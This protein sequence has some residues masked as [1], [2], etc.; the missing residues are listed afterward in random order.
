M[1]EGMISFGT[2]RW[3][4]RAAAGAACLLAA[5]CA[6]TAHSP[7]SAAPAGTPAPG[8]EE[9]TALKQTGTLL[10][11][12]EQVGWRQVQELLPLLDTQPGANFPGVTALAGDLRALASAAP[13]N[14]GVPPIEIGSVVDHNAHFWS[15]YYEI[16]PGDPLM[17]MLHVGLLLAAGEVVRADRVATL[18]INFGRMELE[19]RKELVGLDAHAQIVI[20]VSRGGAEELERLH[21]AKE[22]AKLADQARAELAVWP[23][24][25]VA[26]AQLAAAQQALGRQAAGGGDA[27]ADQSLAELHR[28]DPLFASDGP[29]AGAEPALKET[30]RCWALI[31]DDKATGDDEVLEQFARGAQAAGLDELALVAHSLVA[32][33]HEGSTPLEENF[34]Q[35]SLQR[36]VAPEVAA[37]ICRQ[38][39][40]PDHEWLGLSRDG[41]LPPSNLEGVSVHPQLEQ[42]L[43]VQIAATS[44]WIE[45]GLAQ[46]ADLA[47]DYSER[48]E[49]WAQLLQTDDA[50][51]D[52]RRSLQLKPANEPV[53]YDL[54]VVL[55]DAGD[56]KEAEAVFAEA[57]KR[58]PGNALEQQ[59][60][61]NH[62]FKRGRFAEAE[63]AYAR[64]ARLDPTFAYARIMQHLARLRQGKPGGARL[65]PGMQKR[66][67]WGASLVAFL[68]GRI[69][70]KALFSRL[71][72][73]GGLRYSEEECELY[74][75]LA[76]L[77]LGRGDVAEARRDLH[78]C[79]GTGITSFV[80]YA[81]AWHELRRLNA[82][83]PPP[84]D[85]RPEQGDMVDK[86]PA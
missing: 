17:V 7:P 8:A 64:A 5:G 12:V 81:M 28:I 51:A 78:S 85:E 71:E 70:E 24:N 56:F 31:D 30:R 62:L 84:P 4:L 68:A 18:A 60:W 45:S 39:F 41:D 79:L 10:T 86:Q 50:V 25:P 40:G 69:D 2:H 53:R 72:P 77:A 26:W 74:F 13:T 43:L 80:E 73:Q 66:D 1:A 29:G 38:A 34:V 63:A 16:A 19:Y 22:F 61:G 21:R 48:G 46:G 6:T 57:Q 75:V 54:A 35:A 55:S 83:N 14:R 33:W 20:R 32:G 37:A 59:E 27:A 11:M 42:R 76:Q 36:L 67:P 65:E 82:A 23:R 58:A 52:L 3:N 49:A 44:Y 9:A 47:E 15:A